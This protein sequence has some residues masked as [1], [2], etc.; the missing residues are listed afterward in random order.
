M[1]NYPRLLLDHVTLVYVHEQFL[2]LD[3]ETYLPTFA[4]LA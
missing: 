4:T 1:T 3:V 2:G